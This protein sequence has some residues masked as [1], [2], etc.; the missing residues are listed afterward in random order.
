M[1]S[2][3]CK[4]P[5]TIKA[6][7]LIFILNNPRLNNGSKCY[8]CVLEREKTK[9][10]FRTTYWHISVVLN[11]RRKCRIPYLVWATLNTFKCVSNPFPS[12]Q[13]KVGFWFL[14]HEYAHK[15]MF[16]LTL[17]AAGNGAFSSH[18]SAIRNTAKALESASLLSS[19]KTAS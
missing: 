4:L 2:F 19:S 18:L 3:W 1:H 16:I 9:C 5:N 11:N 15:N 12:I 6:S 8:P 14:S 17:I 7:M 10:N 13:I